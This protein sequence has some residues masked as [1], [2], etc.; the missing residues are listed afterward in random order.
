MEWEFLN[1]MVFYYGLQRNDGRVNN[2]RWSAD[3]FWRPHNGWAVY[4]QFMIDDII[5]NNEPGQDD[6]ASLP[7]RLALQISLRQVDGLIPGLYT[8]LG[9]T[10]VWNDTYQSRWTYENYHYKGLGL[11]YPC[12]GCEEIKLRLNFWGWFPFY[13]KNETIVGRYGDVRLTDLFMVE[14]GPFPV[15][16]VRKNF[17]NRLTAV[18]FWRPSLQFYF[19]WQTCKDPAH[20][21][22]RLNEGSK[23]TVS[24][25]FLAVLSWGMRNHE[26]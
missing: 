8:S 21:L 24:I 1:P 23:Y 5:V 4:G 13:L 22:N 14:K 10:R 2:G 3:F 26:R 20:Y 18:Y 9:Y 15:P 17:V 11:G 19:S 7:D 25:G 12:A 16:P 6:R